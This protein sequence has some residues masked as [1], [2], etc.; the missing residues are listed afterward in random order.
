ME[1]KEFADRYNSL[2]H[3]I[4]EYI[5]NTPH[6]IMYWIRNEEVQRFIEEYSDD[7]EDMFDIDVLSVSL[8]PSIRITFDE[9]PDEVTNIVRF[10]DLLTFRD[11]VNES[12][13]KWNG[14]IKEIRIENLNND[15]KFYKRKVAETEELLKME[16]E[17]HDK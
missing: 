7:Y 1:V 5:V 13:L 16:E 17:N 11:S 12:Y 14:K 15:L 8:S 2:K 4:R 10:C 9:H 6:C 3:D